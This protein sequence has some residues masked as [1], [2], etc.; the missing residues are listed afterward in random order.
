M[1]TVT[2]TKHLLSTGI[3][4]TNTRAG[5]N[6][7]NSWTSGD[8]FVNDDIGFIREEMLLP[9]D[10]FEYLISGFQGS[11]PTL[12][13]EYSHESEKRCDYLGSM[14]DRLKMSNYSTLDTDIMILQLRK[15]TVILGKNTSVSARQHL[16]YQQWTK[17]HRL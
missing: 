9:L 1:A 14:R 15:D 2:I 7:Q 3:I 5:L 11:G 4:K 10:S 8:K 12:A 17:S 13:G 16:P 6:R